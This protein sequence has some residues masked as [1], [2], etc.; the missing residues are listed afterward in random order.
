MGS[1]AMKNHPNPM[2]YLKEHAAGKTILDVGCG[3]KAYSVLSDHVVTVDAWEKVRPDYVINL[4]VDDLEFDDDSFQ[5]VL[6]IDFIEH[7]SK[8][9]GQRLLNQAYRI[10]SERVY[11]LTPLWWD[12]NERFTEDPKLWSYG[13]EFNLHK[14]LWSREDFPG[15]VELGHTNAEGEYFWGYWE[16]GRK[17]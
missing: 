6:M 13:N 7:V 1:A 8:A 4:E 16:C 9:R 3:P 10:A 12:S 15:W 17:E 2:S 11:V 14:S 5:V